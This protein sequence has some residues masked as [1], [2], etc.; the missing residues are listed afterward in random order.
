MDI[1]E[2]IDEWMIINKPTKKMV[3]NLIKYLV[4]KKKEIKPEKKNTKELE[5]LIEDEEK[6]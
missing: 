6:K 1:E 3:N 2:K 5:E 4:E